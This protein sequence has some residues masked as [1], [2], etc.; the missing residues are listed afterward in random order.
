MIRTANHLHGNSFAGILQ[1]GGE[2]FSLSLFDELGNYI[3]AKHNTSCAAGTGSFLDQQAGR[4]DL[5]SSEQISEHALSNTKDRPD[6]A[7]RCAVFAKTDLIH[8]QQEGYDIAQI[9]DGLCFGLAKNIANTLFKQK[10]QFKQNGLNSNDFDSKILFCGGVSKNICVKN[11]LES[12][13]GIAFFMDDASQFYGAIGAALCL[14][15]QLNQGIHE[16]KI[17]GPDD[18]FI[19]TDRKE[20]YRYPKLALTL[21]DYP[22]FT[23]FKSCLFEGVEVDIYQDP[24]T[25]HTAPGIPGD[26]MWEPTTTK[27]LFY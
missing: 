21:S 16:P 7:T 19:K 3:G 8:A 4:L 22:D 13:L 14:K 23:C 26:W 25:S 9:C 20:S 27:T 5:S 2:K 6:I 15:D 24:K 17:L 10:N 12:I 18:Y 1:I 11:H